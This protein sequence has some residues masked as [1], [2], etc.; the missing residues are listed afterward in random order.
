MIKD[1]AKFHSKV[2]RWLKYYK[3]LFPDSFL[4]ET[5]VVR[6]SSKNFPLKELSMKERT[7]LKQAKKSSIIQTHSDYGGMGTN[8]DGSVISGGGYI[9]LQWQRR[10]NKEFYVIDIEELLYFEKGNNKKTLSEDD[11]KKI[12]FI[13]GEL[14]S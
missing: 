8:C 7:L 2:V 6:R 1:E 14:K 11:C 12:N 5:K 10:G 4:F 13:F 9:F 3:K